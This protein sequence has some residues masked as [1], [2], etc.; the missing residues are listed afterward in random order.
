MLARALGAE[1]HTIRS[2]EDFSGL[3]IAAMCARQGPTLL[4][5]HI[6]PDEVPPMNVRMRALGNTL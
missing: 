1:G 2:P 5:V 4:D 3:D 6:D